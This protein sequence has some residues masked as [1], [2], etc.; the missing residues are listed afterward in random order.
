MMRRSRFRWAVGLALLA[1][2]ACGRTEAPP[3]RLTLAAATFA[4]LPGW[5]GDHVAEAAAVREA[6]EELKYYA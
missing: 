2:A 3:D 4:E 6:R 5:T 1:V